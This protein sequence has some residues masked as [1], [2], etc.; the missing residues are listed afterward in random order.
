MIYHTNGKILSFEHPLL[1]GIVNITPDSFYDGGK[2]SGVSDVI[3]DVEQ[4]IAE[5]AHVIDVGGV[6]TR[7]GADEVSMEEEWNR[8]KDVLKEMR[9]VFPEVFISIDTFRSEI[10]L[11]SAEMGADI[12]NDI[13]G[14]RAD[15][16]MF[17]TVAQLKLPY[18]LGHI[19][20]TPKTMQ[21]N[22]VYE[23]VVNEVTDFFKYSIAELNEMGF[24]QLILD[25]GFGFGK[26]LEDNYR[27]LKYAN[28]Y[29]EIGYPVMAGISRKS[30]INKVLGSSPVSSL[31]GTTAVNTMALLNGFKLLRVHDVK[32]AKQVV[33]LY[34]QY[35]SV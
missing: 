33:Q 1:V 8:L 14:G 4:K 22:P 10:A 2:F 27:L 13:Y 18:I 9:R 29:V 11:R 24:Y 19:K 3:R 32:E 34:E 6:S 30:M 21:D 12:I 16:M 17:K 20:G 28:Q 31:N 7:P 26:S 5:G 23:D 25:P 35:K 15:K